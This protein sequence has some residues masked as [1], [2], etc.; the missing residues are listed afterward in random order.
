MPIREALRADLAQDRPQDIQQYDA[1]RARS[2]ALAAPLSPEDQCVQSMPDASPTKWHLAHT[3]WFFETVILKEHLPDYQVFD[4]AFHYLFNSYYESLGP[5]HARPERGLLTRPSLESVHAYRA[6]VDAAMHA[7]LE[8]PH[9]TQAVAPLLQLGLSHEEQHQELLLTDIKH[10]FS[11]NIL[12]PAYRPPVPLAAGEPA[13]LRWVSCAHGGAEIGH[14][15]EG[16]AFDN[17]TP[18]HRV[19]LH[20]YALANRLVS[21]AEYLAFIEDDGY[22]RPEFWLSD[23]WAM[24]KAQG[25]QAPLYW[26]QDEAGHWQVFTLR[27]QRPVIGNEPV[28]HV[29][30]YEAA[31]YAAWAGARLPTETEWEVAAATQAPRGHLLDDALHPTP[32]DPHE[33]GLAQLYGDVWEWTRSSYDP[34]P[35]FRPFSGAAG[36][37]NG[38]FMVGQL[39]LRGGSCATP[40]GHIR[41]SYRNFFPPAARWQFSGI[42]L[43]RDE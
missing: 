15:D 11:R 29:S 33:A 41:A 43:A 13:P 24:V 35:G 18:R 36:E 9:A 16:F 40:P 25:W 22:R 26:E 3:T 17:E 20:P 6:H 27:G 32:A 19:L 7:L 23:G 30:F 2:M 10:L 28:C 21:C 39:V 14:A 38:K 1:V 4:P 34:Y 8:S 5:R 42:R 12:R 31:A 37:Y